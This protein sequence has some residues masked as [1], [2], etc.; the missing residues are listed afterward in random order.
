MTESGNLRVLK[1]RIV[2]LTHQLH[3]GFSFA[4]EQLDFHS[5]KSRGNL[6]VTRVE[7][8]ALLVENGRTLDVM[9]PELFLKDAVLLDLTEMKP[10][11]QIDDEDL[12]AAEEGAGLALREGEI[13]IIHT[14][15]DRFVG[16]EQYWS[17]HPTL[18]ENAADYLAFKRIS[19]LGIDSPSIDQP[20]N[21]ALTVH[22][23]LMRNGVCVI[24]DLCNLQ[25]IDQPRFRLIALPLR[26]RAPSSPVRALAIL[27]DNPENG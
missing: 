2:D 20:R 8:P 27:D 17:S 23:K 3:A 18:S 21:Q 24:E 25:E 14:R 7:S 10:N 15:W 12:E 4:F 1:V 6:P 19:G 5:E 26:I 13:A 11:Q 16:S 9:N 22:S